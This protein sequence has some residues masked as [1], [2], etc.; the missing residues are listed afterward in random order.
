V[1]KSQKDQ[2]MATLAG[3][4]IIGFVVVSCRP[5]RRPRP[6]SCPRLLTRAR[7]SASGPGV[8]SAAQLSPGAGIR[9]DLRATRY[10]TATPR[11]GLHGCQGDR[12]QGSTRRRKAAFRSR[13]AAFLNL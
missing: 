5:T 12:G 9:P 10:A 2:P 8:E 6:R 4:A 3:A 11:I 13:D 1:E 7:I